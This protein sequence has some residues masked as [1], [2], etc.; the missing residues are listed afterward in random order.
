M[1]EKLIQLLVAKIDVI[2][3]L[4]A[5]GITEGKSQ[6]EQIMLLSSAGFKPKEIA[7]TLGTTSNTVRVALSNL[8]KERSKG[9]S[10]KGKRQT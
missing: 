9:E 6:T 7:Q 4:M 5:L 2:I 8:R 3:K 10:R 1:D